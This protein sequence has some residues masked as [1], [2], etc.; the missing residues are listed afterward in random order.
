MEG[1]E[2]DKATLIKENELKLTAFKE[3]LAREQ[4]AEEKKYDC[5]ISTIC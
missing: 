4:L 3:Q 2:M 5:S 1:L